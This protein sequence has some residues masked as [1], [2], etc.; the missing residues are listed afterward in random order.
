MKEVIGIIFILMAF[1]NLKK[2]IQD[3]DEILVTPLLFDKSQEITYQLTIYSFFDKVSRRKAVPLNVSERVSDAIRKQYKNYYLIQMISC[4]VL[5]I[6][7]ILLQSDYRTM[8]L[9]IILTV[10]IL[11]IDVIYKKRLYEV[12]RELI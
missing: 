8:F 1:L 3:E 5:G 4:I 12:L 10:V 6:F 9:L 2:S 7:Y 11:S